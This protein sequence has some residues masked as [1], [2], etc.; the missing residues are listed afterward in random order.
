MFSFTPLLGAQSESRASQS[1]L[2]FDG[3]LKILVDVGWDE[4]FDPGKL[5]DLE[6]H[7]STISIILLTHATPGHL[8]AFA[9]CCKHIP[10]FNRI[11]V[12]A[13][14]PVISLGRALIIDLYKSTPLASCII[15]PSSLSQT[16]SSYSSTLTNGES[17]HILLPPPTPDEISTYFSLIHPLKYSQSHQP[18]GSPFSP[19]LNGLTITPYNSG[20]TLGGTIWHLQHGQESVVYAVDWNQA[21]ENVIS[22]AA[23]LGG[24]GGG[25]VSEQ[26]RKPTAMICSSRGA[27]RTA[28][29]GGRKKRN[30]ILLKMIGTAIAKGGVVLIPT[31]SSARVIELAYLLEHAW[32]NESVKSIT[33]NPFKRAKLYLAARSVGMT[34]RYARSMLEWMDEG[35]VREFESEGSGDP[36]KQQQNQVNGRQNGGRSGKDR[37]E[38]QGSSQ[39]AGPFDFRHLQLLERKRD[40]QRALRNATKAAEKGTRAGAVI[41]ASDTSLEWGYSRDVLQQLASDRTNLVILTERLGGLDSA[42]NSGSTG[43][44]QTLWSWWEESNS[45]DVTEEVSKLQDSKPVFGEGREV[46]IRSARRASLEGNELRIYQQYLATQQQLHN[47]LAPG[48]SAILASSADAVDDASSTESTLSDESDSERQGKA[49]NTSATLANANR[50][51]LQLTNEE[52]GVNV[53]LRRKGVY[54]FYVCG[55]KGRDRMFPFVARRQRN[56]EFGEIIRPDEYLKAE[57]RDEVN[58]QD[59]RNTGP[60]KNDARPVLGQKRKWEDVEPH[61]SAGRRQSSTKAPRLMRDSERNPRRGRDIDGLKEGPREETEP[62]DDEVAAQ[63]SDDEESVEMTIMGPSKV[64]FNTD[65]IKINLRIAFVDFAGLHDKR[66]LQ[67]LI[68]L[69][70]PRKLILVEG[71]KEETLALATDCRQLLSAKPGDSSHDSTVSVYT[72][73]VGRTIDASVDTNAWTVKLN[74]HLA[75]RL[76]WQTVRGLG[77]VHVNGLLAAKPVADEPEPRQGASKKQKTDRSGTPTVPQGD[78]STEP[79]RAPDGIPTLEPVPTSL[80]T[81]TRSVAQPLHVGDLRLA[82]LKRILQT[83]GHVAE[84]RGEGTLL[85]DGLVAIRKGGTGK[86]EVEGGDLGTSRAVSGS[87]GNEGSFNAIK[88]KIYEGLAVVAGA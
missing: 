82:D 63:S 51:K 53:L 22:G 55:K 44:G 18:L 39:K 40:V 70:E 65:T 78:G 10:L 46:H 6:R 12:Y 32:R 16:S 86:I 49:L 83:S 23:W 45:D 85:V 62:S 1:L 52:L 50:N 21:R 56:D 77:V 60:G 47:T 61:D 42:F 69:I 80:A 76:Q 74:D 68:P 81:S 66:S 20:H 84:F 14:T 73:V 15:P 43:L 8:A 71:S 88:R 35:I 27:E 19:P 58:G 7:V 17:A 87:G 38:E 33:D 75:R 2:E 41:L 36:A 9:H 29:A 57:E 11:P 30:E 5:K 54:D 34:M 26:L 79:E 37:R 24:T 64:V 67:M 13:T 25:E 31:D 4:T 59:M 3:G 48:S 28:F 72:P